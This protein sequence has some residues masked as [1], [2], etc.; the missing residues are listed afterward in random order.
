MKTQRTNKAI[1][2]VAALLVLRGTITGGTRPPL[3]ALAVMTCHQ[4]Q[5]PEPD[6][7]GSVTVP[8]PG[9]P[10]P[11]SAELVVDACLLPVG[12]PWGRCATHAPLMHHPCTTK[13]TLA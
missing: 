5:G 3:G 13:T 4:W 12:S 7:S 8:G 11:L 6:T 9:L 2:E 1:A 10:H